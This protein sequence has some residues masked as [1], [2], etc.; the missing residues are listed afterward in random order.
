MFGGCRSWA[1]LWLWGE[2]ALG[3]AS[4]KRHPLIVTGWLSVRREG[5]TVHFQTRE[6]G[7]KGPDSRVPRGLRRVGRV[8]RAQESPEGIPRVVS[9]SV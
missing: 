7:G 9:E 5:E 6:K 1:W 8:I 4:G 2:Q 3:T